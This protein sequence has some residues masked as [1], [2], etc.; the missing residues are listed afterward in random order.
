MVEPVGKGGIPVNT[1]VVEE[2]QALLAQIQVIKFTASP[3]NVEPFQNHDRFPH[4]SQIACDAKS[5]R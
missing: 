3:A 4:Q 2:Q 5:F 1:T